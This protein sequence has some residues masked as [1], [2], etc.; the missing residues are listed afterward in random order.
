MGDGGIKNKKSKSPGRDGAA[1]GLL[2]AM[3]VYEK[4]S[5]KQMLLPELLQLHQIRVVSYRVMLKGFD[6]T[7]NTFS[8]FATQPSL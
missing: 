3:I 5:D 7:N 8:F 2:E 4:L 6:G 1:R